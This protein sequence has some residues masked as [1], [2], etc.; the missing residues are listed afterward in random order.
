[1]VAGAEALARVHLLDLAHGFVVEDDP[2]LPHEHRAEPVQRQPRPIVERVTA[3]THNASRSLQM[4]LLTNALSQRR[5]Q[6][7]RIDNRV[8]E[9]GVARF[10]PAPGHVQL[11]GTVAALA[12]D[13]R[14]RQNRLA[15]AIHRVIYR[16]CIVR[17]AEQALPVDRTLKM[18]V[19]LL[20]AGREVPSLTL[21]VPAD[22]RLE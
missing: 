3:I 9:S 5:R 22:R 4:A 18:E 11:A 10:L 17:M 20:V 13:G 21:R 1:T 19:R 15:V 2:L 12:A 14:P 16:P 8:I 7:P 6:V